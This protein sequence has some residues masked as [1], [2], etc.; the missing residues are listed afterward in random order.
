MTDDRGAEGVDGLRYNRK[1]YLIPPQSE[2]AWAMITGI[3]AMV[4]PLIVIKTAMRSP[5][6][7]VILQKTALFQ[8]MISRNLLS[9]D[10]A[11]K[12]ELLFAILIVARIL[13][14][15]SFFREHASKYSDQRPPPDPLRRLWPPQIRGRLYIAGTLLG[16]PLLLGVVMQHGIYPNYMKLGEGSLAILILG[17]GI[18]FLVES[19]FAVVLFSFF[20]L[21]Y[22]SHLPKASP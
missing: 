13:G 4:I 10:Q 7:P 16:G 8:L 18:W 19:I 3:Y 21:R 12:T 17:L 9:V 15:S 6:S 11:A 2:G 14:F 1:G 5:F 22:W 20:Y